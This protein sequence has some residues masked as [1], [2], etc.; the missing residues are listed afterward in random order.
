MRWICMKHPG[1]LYQVGFNKGG[2]FH[3][4]R[5]YHVQGDALKRCE[6]LNHLKEVDRLQ[7]LI[8]FKASIDKIIRQLNRR[9][10]NLT[11]KD[12]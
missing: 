3:A 9:I 12:K 11:P 6:Q 2:D 10:R 5:K 8:I 4:D 1:P 7:E